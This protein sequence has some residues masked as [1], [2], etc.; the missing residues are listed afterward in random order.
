[1]QMYS[2]I[3]MKFQSSMLF[4]A[5]LSFG[6]FRVKAQVPPSEDEDVV[7]SFQPSLA[8][9][10]GVL[11]IMFSLT[12]L[13]LLYAKFCH[14]ASSSVRNSTNIMHIQDGLVRSVLSCSSGID[15][16]V[17]ESL[18]FFR[19]SF[20]RGSK[21]GLECV[22][23]LSKFEDIEILRLLPK[24]KHAF[25]IDC[26]D[27]WLEKHSTCPLCRHKVSAQD[28]SLLT[29]S[30]SL[31]FLWNQPELREESNLEL[32][33]QRG[34]NGSSR[35][36][37]G[38]SFKKEEEL[39][40]QENNIDNQQT[41]YQ[42]Q[43]ALH[44]FNHRI[45]VSDVV[46]KNRWSTVTSSDLIFLNSEMLNS[47][48]SNRFSSMDRISEQS[49]AKRVIEEDQRVNI[50]D[51]MERKRLFESKIQQNDLSQFP[52]AS[53]S[54]TNSSKSLSQNEK[55]CMSEIIVHPRFIDFNNKNI[56]N[57]KLLVP[58]NNVNEERR[59]KLWLPIARRT[60][61]WFANRERRPENRRQTLNV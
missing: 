25:H 4:I 24:C 58:Q 22:V 16:T 32:Y 31:R 46:F 49:T 12:F 54:R 8:V 13:L 41:D 2:W 35:F 61:K 28:L 56:G 19:F 52:E 42:N 57:R 5:I 45:I 40:I 43:K 6:L 51:E 27:K 7:S 15:K 55:K 1:M 47:M 38:S 34:E 26:I 9:V 48:A 50:K 36:S 20:I 23:C 37:I 14:M 21:Q 3:L 30:D 29:Y 59:R 10:I 60:V 33:I 11:S 44:R 17:V 53:E 39:P 18:P